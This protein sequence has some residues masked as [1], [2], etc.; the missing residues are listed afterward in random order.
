MS[1]TRTTVGAKLHDDFAD[2]DF[3][4]NPTW[5]SGSGTQSIVSGAIQVAASAAQGWARSAVSIANSDYFSWRASVATSDYTLSQHRIEWGA[6]DNRASTYYGII[7]KDGAGASSIYTN[8]AG[9]G[10]FTASLSDSNFHTFAVKW[11]GTSFGIYRDDT[12]LTTITDSTYSS[13]AAIR[14]MAATTTAS[15]VIKFDDICVM[16]GWNVTCSGLP[17]GWKLRVISDVGGTA[18]ATATESSGTATVD[19]TGK[20]AFPYY[21]VQVLDGSSVVQQTLAPSATVSGHTVSGVFGGDAYTYGDSGFGTITL[22]GSAADANTTTTVVGVAQS[23]SDA[24]GIDTSAKYSFDAG[25]GTVSI[26]GGI[27]TFTDT[28][29]EKLF[30]RNDL[31]AAVDWTLTSKRTRSGTTAMSHGLTARRIDASNY[32]LIQQSGGTLAILK[33]DGGSFSDLATTAVPA[34]SASTSYWVRATFSG[35]S[36]TAERFIADPAGG[37]TATH[38]VSY[39]LTGAD[40]TKFG[41]VA[42]QP[43]MRWTFTAIDGTGDDFTWS[44]SAIPMFSLSGSASESLTHGGN[45]YSDAPSGSVT[46]SGTK[47]GSNSGNETPA[48][49]L[50]LLPTGKVQTTGWLARFDRPIDSFTGPGSTHPSGTLTLSGTA[51][52][53]YVFGGPIVRLTVAITD[54]SVTDLV[55]ADAGVTSLVLSDAAV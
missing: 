19:L 46:L 51:T 29:T 6:S 31:F 48:G 52:D 30:R 38:S 22:S 15:Q 37:A 54:D 9:F 1:L 20:C 12:L 33:K 17:T 28:T 44:G 11:N 23:G 36:L 21:G 50:T 34:D 45:T 10:T 25:S 2:G 5:I 7:F 27:L 16:D 53:S 8:V 14:V 41:S 39:T 40:A 3:T 42:A 47:T 55:I 24:F 26:A 35:N 4:S 49:T 18:V 43:G 32:L 13:A